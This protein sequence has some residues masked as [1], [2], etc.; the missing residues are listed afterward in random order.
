MNKLAQI[1]LAWELNRNN[2]PKVTISTTLGIHRETVAIWIARINKLGG[3]VELF[4]D[5]YLNAKKGERK[6]RKID[7]LL[8]ARIYRIR[9]ENRDCC[10]QK[11]KEYLT[12]EFGQSP[13]L[14][15][16]YKILGEKYQLRSKWKKNQPR[17]PVPKADRPRQVV[18][19]D[20]VDFGNIFAF[21]GIDIFSKDIAVK[22]YPSLTSEEGEDYLHHAFQTRFKHTSLLQ[23]DGGREF[24]DKFKKKVFLYADRFRVARPYRKNEQAY[25]E[26]FNRS[27]RKECL[28]WSKY[29]KSELPILERELDEYLVYYHTKRVHLSL[30]MKTPNEVLKSYQLMTNF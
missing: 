9:E 6:K 10:G 12:Q 4:I 2:M 5:Q 16:I 26:A 29:S 19:M 22:L 21:T 17:G 3:N 30:D 7:G 11:I 25:I 20:T 1:A 18:Q 28:G 27:L 14:T 23:T 15:M 8:K 13:G 24:K